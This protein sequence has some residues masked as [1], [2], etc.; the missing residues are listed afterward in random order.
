MIKH[1]FQLQWRAFLRASSFKTQL[2]AK[3]LTGFIA[4]FYLFLIL[5]LGFMAY[6]G[7]HDAGLEPLVTVN[8]YILI[9]LA[10]DLMMR[11]FLQKMPILSIIPLLT[12]PVKKKVI[13]HYLFGRSVISFFNIYPFLFF[14]PFSWALIENGYDLS[15]VIA[16]M[17][18][19]LLLPFI[20]HFLI[21]L[22]NGMSKVFLVLAIILTIIG[23]A[24]YYDYLN[25]CDY[26]GYLFQ[27]F[28]RYPFL[29][30]IMSGLVVFFYKYVHN[31]YTKSLYLDNTDT[32]KVRYADKFDFSWLGRFG[33]TAPLIKND[34]KSLLRNKR[35]RRILWVSLYFA[36]YFVE[37]VL[38]SDVEISG[39]DIILRCFFCTGGLMMFFGQLIPGWDSSYYSLIS[40]QNITV[41]Q[42]LTSK[43]MIITSS[44]ILC[45]ILNSYVLFINPKIYMYLLAL[46]AYNTGITTPIVLLQGAYCKRPIHLNRPLVLFE[47]STPFSFRLIILGLLS[48]M[49]PFLFYFMAKFITIPYADIFLIS[50]FGIVGIL[51]RNKLFDL[52][53]EMYKSEKYATLKALRE[54]Q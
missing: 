27:S 39:F 11:Y 18:S 35:G 31:L 41:K 10:G 17:I 28:F 4:V 3:I 45:L 19:M 42:Y 21:I 2:A 40:T 25:V 23:A 12:T 22:I 14:V 30:F 7:L 48:M 47:S 54:H 34:I 52:L 46:A 44:V 49:I 20:N 24:Y 37:L 13:V 43:W 26:S 5:A 36:L 29:V 33:E 50:A 32:F 9:W 6:Y 1:L 38:K 53:A 51:F 8:Q 15:G 16:W